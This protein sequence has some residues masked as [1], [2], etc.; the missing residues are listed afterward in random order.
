M[1]HYHVTLAGELQG[2]AY[3]A[4][5]WPEAAVM[6]D[7]MLQGETPDNLVAMIECDAAD[8]GDYL[9]MIAFEAD[10]KRLRSDITYL[11]SEHSRYVIESDGHGPI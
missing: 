6:F 11:D 2:W 5:A 3:T 4:H 1:S 8:C 10:A 9:D 7:E